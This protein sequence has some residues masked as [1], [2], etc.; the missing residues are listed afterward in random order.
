MEGRLRQYADE[1]GID[2][3]AVAGEGGAGSVG[4]P[5]NVPNSGGFRTRKNYIRSFSDTF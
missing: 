5:R 2:N 3:A 4:G 1:S